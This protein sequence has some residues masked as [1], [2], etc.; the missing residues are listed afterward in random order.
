MLFFTLVFT[1][2]WRDVWRLVSLP[3]I[4]LM[5]AIAAPWHILIGM[6]NPGFFW[7]YFIN[8]HLLR[9][10]G[11]RYPMDYGTVPLVPFWAL[12]M[13]WLFPWSFY[14]VTLFVPSQFTRAMVGTGRRW[15]LPLAWAFTIL[16]FFACSWRLE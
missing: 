7:F 15:V 14:L 1:R 8:E 13:V 2:R 10:L 16:L 6:R 5:L 4:L 11:K 12:H 3:C 9:F